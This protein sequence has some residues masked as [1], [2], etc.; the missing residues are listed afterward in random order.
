MIQQTIL[1]QLVFLIGNQKVKNIIVTEVTVCSP[2]I[3]YYSQN[4]W[5]FRDMEVITLQKD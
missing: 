4:P 2:V 3:T 1:S 5:N